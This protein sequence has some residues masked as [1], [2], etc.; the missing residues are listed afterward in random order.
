M[1][2]MNRQFQKSAY[3]LNRNQNQNRNNEQFAKEENAGFKNGRCSAVESESP[4]NK[5]LRKVFKPSH[6]FRASVRGFFSLLEMSL[7]ME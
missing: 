4:I 6:G 7:V 3:T 2:A 1:S 5:L